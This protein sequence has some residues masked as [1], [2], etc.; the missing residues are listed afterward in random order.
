MH[1]AIE[2]KRPDDGMP[3]S[4][5]EPAADTPSDNLDFVAFSRAFDEVR[6][7]RKALEKFGTARLDNP[8]PPEVSAAQKAFVD[9]VK[10]YKAVVAALI[11]PK[12]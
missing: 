12:F 1:E 4:G 6:E 3:A 5:D 9:A 8:P 10:R 2:P 7:A 11:E